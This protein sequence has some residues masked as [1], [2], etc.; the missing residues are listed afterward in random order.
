LRTG[1]I[2]PTERAHH[3]DTIFGGQALFGERAISLSKR[4]AQVDKHSANDVANHA[5]PA[6]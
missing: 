2:D 5:A 1:R 6:G 3:S 4:A